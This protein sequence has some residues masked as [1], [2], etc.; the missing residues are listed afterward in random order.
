[1]SCGKCKF[2]KE[3]DRPENKGSGICRRNPPQITTRVYTNGPNE[4]RGLDYTEVESL[5]KTEWPETKATD[6][7][8]CFVDPVVEEKISTIRALRR[9][10]PF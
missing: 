1:M 7:C 6:W 10:V 3:S 9:S 8:G 2:W 5:A 4:N